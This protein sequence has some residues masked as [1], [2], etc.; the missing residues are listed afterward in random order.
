MAS[1]RK[2]KLTL[3]GATGFTGGLCAEYLARA[4]PADTTWAIAGR[5]RD[6][7]DSTRQR[8]EKAGAS[9]LPDPIVANTE[10]P[11]SLADM[12][13]VSDVV[14]TTVGP[15]IFHGEG[16]ARACAEQGTHYCDLTGEPEFV[17][18]LITRYHQLAQENGCALINSCGFDSIPHDAGVLYTL[19]VLE[20]KYGARLDGPVSVEGVLTLSATVSGGTWQSALTALGRPRQHRESLRRARMLLRHQYPRKAGSLPMRIRH[21]GQLGGWLCP[22]PTI[23]PL[24][25]QRSARAVED[26]GPDFRYGH[27][28][29]VSGLSRL[30]VG[31]AGIGG[32]ALAAQVGPVR[33]WLMQTRASGEGPSEDKREQ[34]WFRVRFRGHHGDNTVLCEVSGGDP[35]YGETARM[36]SETAMA[37]ALDEDLPLRAGVVTPVMGLEDRLITR[38]QK[39]GLHFRQLE[40]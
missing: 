22:M 29:G 32:L 9:T 21:D 25:V 30:A 13:A 11:T 18:N 5:N 2:Y 23:D 40:A 20:E 34:S 31:A 15:Y 19:R 37:L 28:L 35:G 16:V 3:L 4:L 10:D 1:D 12:A 33:R 7:L 14:I 36:L 6:K 8:L 27:F 38:M 26:Y 39:A 24:V 17:N